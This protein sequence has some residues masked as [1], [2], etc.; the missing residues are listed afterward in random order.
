MAASR[1]LGL[2]AGSG[3]LPIAFA[4]EAVKK[5]YLLQTA[6]IRGAASPQLEKLSQATV[7][8]AVGQVGKLLSFFKKRM[9][10][11][12]VIHGKVQHSSLYQHLK[13]D[14]KALSLLARMKDHSGASI[15]KTLARE[16][17]KNGTRLLDGRFLMEDFLPHRGL[18]CGPVPEGP[19]LESIRFGIGKAGVLAREGIGQTL[20]VKKKA[21]VA[22]EAM[23]GTDETIR[24]AGQWAGKGAIVVKV[25]APD[26]D[27]RFDVP[28]VGPG[29]VRAMAKV[30]ARG[31][32]IPEG[33]AFLLEREKTLAIAKE[34]GMF[35][36]VER[37]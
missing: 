34:H 24:R 28:T 5:G 31:L 4:K 26:Q 25:A 13:M 21:V 12:A 18:V 23:E 35:I 17:S 19:L 30:Q 14:L 6:A 3:E 8:I 22:V 32:V 9:V 1:V 36:W 33:E 15:L 16:L 29:T 10:R 37:D 11:Q 2:I 20:V 27:W 7:W